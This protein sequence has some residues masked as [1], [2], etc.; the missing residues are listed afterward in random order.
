[1]PTWPL[2][3]K[4]SKRSNATA[5]YNISQPLETMTSSNIAPLLN[6][7]GTTGF[8]VTRAVYQQAGSNPL[9]IPQIIAPPGD[10]DAMLHEEGSTWQGER[11]LSFVDSVDWPS[12][13]DLTSKTLQH[14]VP[15]SRESS[16]PQFGSLPLAIDEV[17]TSDVFVC[18]IQRI[19]LM[20]STCSMLATCAV[21][22]VCRRGL[23]ALPD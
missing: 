16:L 18:A 17:V 10:R 9:G 8:E 6:R 3:R 7:P 5:G 19:V 13:V 12:F 15:S 4:E 1:M 21:C 2:K 14:G 23:A 20:Q 22:V 11:P